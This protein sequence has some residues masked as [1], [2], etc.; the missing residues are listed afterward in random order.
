MGK[1]TRSDI[2]KALKDVPASS[3]VSGARIKLTAK[4][5]KFVEG[6]ASD[7]TQA[8][9]YREAY[10]TKA[11]PQ[12][13]AVKASHLAKQDKI[14]ASLAAI[15]RAQELQA[16]QSA[17][18]LRA[19]AVQTFVDVATDPDSKAGDRLQAARSLGQITEVALFTSR[20]ES[21]VHHSS[22]TIKAKLL[23]QLQSVMKAN[24]I[25]VDHSAAS[26]LDE[27]SASNQP[28]SVANPTDCHSANG[29]P[30]PIP[31]DP[32]CEEGTLDSMHSNQPEQLPPE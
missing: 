20:T 32:F 4:Q 15:Q 29:E 10:N 11:D 21:V 24:V 17:A 9:S 3:I 31:H 7:K 14:Q 2:S 28:E 18:Q 8:Q 13:V 5:R 27:L 1:V 19:L 22:D 26:L 25:N 23:E 6:L 30:Y 12:N 16:S